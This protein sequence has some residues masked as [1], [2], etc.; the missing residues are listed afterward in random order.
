ML[1]STTGSGAGGNISLIAG[2]SVRSPMVLPSLPARAAQ[3]MRATFSS[4]RMT[5][6]SAEVEP[7]L[8]LQLEQAMPE[9]SRFKAQ[10]VRQIL[11]LS[12]VQAV[13]SLQHRDTGAGGNI[14][15]MPT[16]SRCRTVAHS[17][18]VGLLN[19][20]RRQH[21]NRGAESVHMNNGATITRAAPVQ[22]APA[23]SR[24]TPATNSR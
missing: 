12:T 16:P 5:S 3:A 14:L 19:G 6:R 10:T 8:L 11:S 1:E 21:H 15:S 4:R 24:S 7:L 23:T 2:Q 22:A 18:N 17:A 20:H 9:P 13:A